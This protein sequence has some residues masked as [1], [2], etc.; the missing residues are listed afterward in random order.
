MISKLLFLI[1]YILTHHNISRGEERDFDACINIFFIFDLQL[2]NYSVATTEM[3]S[4]LLLHDMLI[5][6]CINY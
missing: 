6:D 1:I 2:C 5:V 4:A 3:K